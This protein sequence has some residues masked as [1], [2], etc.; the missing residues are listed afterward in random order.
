MRPVQYFN[1]DYLAQSSKA[2]PEQVLAYLEQ[3]RLLQSNSLKTAPIKS[4]LI[5]MKVQ[6]DLLTTFRAKCEIEGLKY[7]SQIKVLMKQ[8]LQSGS[9]HNTY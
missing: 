9:R 4:K 2:T 5:S 6:E 3:F 1:D 8:W 7:Q